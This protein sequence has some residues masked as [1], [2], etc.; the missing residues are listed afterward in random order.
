MFIDII[1]K[2]IDNIDDLY[3]SFL[4]DTTELNILINH[5][6][7]TKKYQI[8]TYRNR[9]SSTINHILIE[10][11]EIHMLQDTDEYNHITL[12]EDREHTLNFVRKDVLEYLEDEEKWR[13]KIK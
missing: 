8:D 11:D 12:T 3:L 6:S 1:N 7:D 13:N 2:K 5:L 4:C 9:I 10:Y